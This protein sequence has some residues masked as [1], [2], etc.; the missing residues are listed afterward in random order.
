MTATGVEAVSDLCVI[1]A[2]DIEFKTVAKLLHAGTPT[3]ENGLKVLRGRY[4]ARQVTL[5]KTEI[6]ASGFAEKLQTHLAQN[7][8][9]ALLVFG[10]AGALDPVLRTGDVVLYDR[11]L[12][13]RKLEAALRRGKLES[14]SMTEVVGG[15]PGDD[16]LGQKLFE[17]FG[18]QGLRCQRGAGLLVA[19]VVIES[20]QKQA[21][22]AHTNAA[23]IDMETYLV[24]AVAAEFQL[25]CAAV[26]VVMDEAA[27]D[28]PDF[29]AGLDDTGRMRLWPTLRALAARPRATVH[30]LGTLRPALRH[31]TRAAEAVFQACDSR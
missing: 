7:H 10:L 28:L 19:R 2:A 22:Y 1:T 17:G 26:R 30:F 25:P 3:V 20:Q 4:S 9:A 15:I 27:S 12:D 14:R 13:G 18:K 31:L 16:S 29:N 23:A 21:L 5:L 11:C 24:W 6:G 8:Y